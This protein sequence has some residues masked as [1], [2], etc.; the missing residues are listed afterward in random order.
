MLLNSVRK[1]AISDSINRDKNAI[2]LLLYFCNI[3]IQDWYK[4]IIHKFDPLIV[5]EAATSNRKLTAIELAPLTKFIKR[6]YYE[7]LAKNLENL[8]KKVLERFD[9]GD[10]HNILEMEIYWTERKSQIY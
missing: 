1:G 10:L 6:R 4:E 9:K 8:L 2:C 5:K 7:P 3:F